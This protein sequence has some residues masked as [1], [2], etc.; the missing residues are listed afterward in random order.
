MQDNSEEEEEGKVS[1][2][3][4]EDNGLKETLIG[5]SLGNALKVFRDAGQLGKESIR[6]RNK[7]QS[8][9]NQ[10]ASFVTNK[11]PTAKV[12]RVDQNEDRVKLQYLDKKGNKLSIKEAYRNMCYKFHGHKPSHA[13]RD[14]AIKKEEAAGKVRK[15]YNKLGALQ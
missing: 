9:D 8:L 1:D 12:G 13:Q 15:A 4:P 10:L 7:D 11:D 6:G 2:P 5:K 3:E 14:K